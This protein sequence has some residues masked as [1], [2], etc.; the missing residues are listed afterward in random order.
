M[1]VGESLEGQDEI[2]FVATYRWMRSDSIVSITERSTS[3][4]FVLA[5]AAYD[6]AR[7]HYRGFGPVGRLSPDTEFLHSEFYS[8]LAEISDFAM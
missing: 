6:V 3:G 1:M 7:P 5:E 8:D 2:L 4:P